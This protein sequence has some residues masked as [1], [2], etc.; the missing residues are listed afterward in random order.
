MN[1]TTLALLRAKLEEMRFIMIGDV[2]EKCKTKIDNPNEQVADIADDAAQSYNRQLM[3]EFGENEWKKL[4]LV[5]E[6]L[7][8]MG[9]GQYG[10]CSECKKSI[11]EVRLN[12]IPFTVHCIDCLGAIEKK[13]NKL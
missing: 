12:I 8:N 1:D 13:S 10:I 2:K 9:N 6:A 4:R 3:M 7:E 5:E 11:P